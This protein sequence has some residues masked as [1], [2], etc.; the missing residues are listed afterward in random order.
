MAIVDSC[1]VGCKN[2]RHNGLQLHHDVQCG[3]GS[4]LE[5]V[6]NSVALH[7]RIMS[8]ASFG[9]RLLL[10]LSLW[11]LGIAQ[12]WVLQRQKQNASKCCS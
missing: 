6:P 3:A 11:V 9:G 1:K 8:F 4:V 10:L 5:R 2:Q 7:G 12:L